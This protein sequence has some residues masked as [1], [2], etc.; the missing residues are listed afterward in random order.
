MRRIEEVMTTGAL[1]TVRPT[2]TVGEVARLI[3][4]REVSHVIVLADGEVAGV[5]CAATSTVRRRRHSSIAT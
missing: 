3:A 2:A 1:V 4:E 5:V